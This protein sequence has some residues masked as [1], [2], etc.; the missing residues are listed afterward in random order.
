MAC[1]RGRGLGRACAWRGVCTA[2]LGKVS[3]ARLVRSG[4]VWVHNVLERRGDK[5]PLG[6]Q[7]S[8]WVSWGVYIGM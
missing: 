3:A 1:R 6:G 8:V 5:M 4:V 2:P 7:A